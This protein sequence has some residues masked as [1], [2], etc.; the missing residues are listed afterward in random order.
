M[1]MRHLVDPELLSYGESYPRITL[2]DE[3]I[4]LVRQSDR[5]VRAVDPAERNVSKKQVVVPSPQGSPNDGVQCYLYEPEVRKDLPLKKAL[6]GFLHFHGG[7]YIA[8]SPERSEYRLVDVVARLGVTAVAASYRLAPENPYPAG[9]DDAYAVLS[10][11][12]ENAENLGIDPNRIAVGGDSAG[13]GLA[14]ALTQRNREQAQHQI[15]HQQLVYPMLDDRTTADGAPVDPT[16]AEY[17]WTRDY[18]RYAWD[19]YL[20]NTKPAAPAVP[21][22][23]ENFENL[24]PAWI[25]VG[26]LDLFL[27]ENI[28]YAR[29]LLRAGVAT[30]LHIYPSA[31]HGFPHA[32]AAV[33]RR[34]HEDYI[35]ALARGLKVDQ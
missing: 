32:D 21:A 10:W 27:N 22:R 9:L 3:V 12:F 24:P 8:G 25:A 34:F 26:A 30:E 13:G 18:N 19:R 28:A 4:P 23:A 14:A 17:S 20:A 11:L 2:T 15:I 16:V 6:P 1:T 35:Q 7:G 5:K 29:S 33:S 31:F